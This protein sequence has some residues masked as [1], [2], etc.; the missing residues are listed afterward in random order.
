MLKIVIAFTCL[1]STLKSVTAKLNKIELESD[2]PNSYNRAISD[3]NKQQKDTLAAL[4]HTDPKDLQDLM[5]QL[6]LNKIE[7]ESDDPDSYNRAIA[8]LNKQQKETLAALRHTDP[9]DLQDL[10]ELNKIEEG[11]VDPAYITA[12]SELSENQKT[13]L[14]GLRLVKPGDQPDSFIRPEVLPENSQ[15]MSTS[16]PKSKIIGKENMNENQVDGLFSGDI[17]T[18]IASGNMRGSPEKVET[19]SNSATTHTT[20]TTVKVVTAHPSYAPL[21]ALQYMQVSQFQ[22]PYVGYSV[23]NMAQVGKSIN[24]TNATCTKLVGIETIALGS[25]YCSA[26]GTYGVSY[27]VVTPIPL[28]YNWN[29]QTILQSQVWSTLYPNDCT[30]TKSH[31]FPQNGLQFY[32]NSICSANALR[33]NIEVSL[34][35]AQQAPVSTAITQGVLETFYRTSTCAN[36]NAQSIGN[37]LVPLGVCIND[38]LFNVW[39]Q[40]SYKYT[41]NNGYPTKTYYLNIDCTGGST[42][43]TQTAS[44]NMCQPSNRM[45]LGSNAFQTTVCVSPTT[46]CFAGSESLQMEDGSVKKMPDISLGDRVLAADNKGKTSFSTVIALPHEKNNIASKFTHITTESGADI[47]LTPDH[48]IPSGDCRIPVVDFSVVKAVDVEVGSCVSTINGKD[49]VATIE[50]VSDSGVYTVVTEQEY[51]V[52]NGIIASPYALSHSLGHNFYNIHRF[53]QSSTL[54]PLFRVIIGRFQEQVQRFGNMLASFS[55]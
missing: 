25:C 16:G 27:Q 40:L 30:C 49:R 13:A 19:D 7:L 41:C 38:N 48:L 45:F 21:P 4:R 8:D 44:S 53:F 15:K 22:A 1:M 32:G 24:N 36:N 34:I 20:V 35:Q 3:L 28:N 6:K 54:L 50:M 12:L 2:D 9:K 37:K 23:A 33:Y 51:I 55:S 14:S 52:V 43:I 10:M 11:S 39:S 42:N 47:K 46:S 31:G 17:R 29:Q 26:D 5:M 18:N